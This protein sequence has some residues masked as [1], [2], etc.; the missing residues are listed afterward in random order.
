[1]SAIRY[2]PYPLMILDNQKTLVLANEAMG[3]LL[4]I[5]DHE[6]V[7]GEKTS[8]V[9]NL[10]GKT[11]SQ[12][13]ID[14][15]QNGKPTWIIWDSFLDAVAR[16]QDTE[17]E[18]EKLSGPIKRDA[19]SPEYVSRSTGTTTSSGLHDTV[20]E[21]LISPAVISATYSENKGL[22]AAPFRHTY[23][24]LIITV[25]GLDE[26]RY[27]TLTFTNTDTPL[28]RPETLEGG[29]SKRRS[30]DPT[31][32][33]SHSASTS[34]V[35]KHDSFPRRASIASAITNPTNLCTSDSPFPAL[36][37]PSQKHL[38]ST[39]SSLQQLLVMK[40]ALLDS[41]EIPI[42]AM[43]K[44]FGLTISNKAARQMFHTDPGLSDP[45]NGYDLVTTWHAW[46]EAF[47]VPLQAEEHPIVELI[48][49][50]RPFTSRKVGIKDKTGRK[51]TYDF[52]GEAIRD[53]T[54]GEFLAG[55]V[56]ARNITQMTEEIRDMKAKDEQRFQLICA[57]MPQM[58]WT[59]TPE[60]MA[61]WFSERW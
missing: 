36:G 58:I 39:S 45:K 40:D 48:R 5:E 21:V 20:I 6:G 8:M 3:R 32:S 23:A 42:L 47:T 52:A 51:Q 7:T 29:P 31:V 55:M 27:F 28:R 59:S 17:I 13:G 12:L 37:P 18:S 46:N 19:E 49:T 16:E 33:P 54:T 34:A 4:D 11:M 24:K 35:L 26:Q 38:H 61:E 9:G 57:S 22:K 14:V 15:L 43:W 50:E 44:D 30:Q 53:E 60:G 41:T 25:W 1:M 2:L 56:T 10:W